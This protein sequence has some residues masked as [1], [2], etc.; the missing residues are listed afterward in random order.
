MKMSRHLEANLTPGSPGFAGQ[1]VV[2]DEDKA[3]EK[4]QALYRSGVGTLF[5]LTKH[6]R[7]D[8]TN[9]VR[10]LFKSM[11]GASNCN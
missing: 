9:A 4:D 3:T 10:E 7:P 11:D 2:E 5:Y 1:K 8:I 6:S